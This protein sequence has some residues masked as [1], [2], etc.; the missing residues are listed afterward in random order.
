MPACAH[1]AAE[2]DTHCGAPI[3]AA[4]SS[5]WRGCRPSVQA[6][7]PAP[8]FPWSA[9]VTSRK[10]DSAGKKIAAKAASHL[11][12]RERIPRT[13]EFSPGG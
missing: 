10:L 1:A 7:M 3:L 6:G 5:F 2:C 8:Q 9:H 4:F 11:T 12:L 13:L